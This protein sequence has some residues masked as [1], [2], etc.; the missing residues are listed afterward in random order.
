MYTGQCEGFKWDES[1][2]VIKGGG[3]INLEGVLLN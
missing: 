3:C 2:G 1:N